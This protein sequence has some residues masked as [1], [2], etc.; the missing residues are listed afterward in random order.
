MNIIIEGLWFSPRERFIEEIASNKPENINNV[1]CCQQILP[2]DNFKEIIR[3]LT[4]SAS[5]WRS[6]ATLTD[7]HTVFEGSPMSLQAY[8]SALLEDKQEHNLFK[9]I[10]DGLEELN[11]PPHLIVIML[12]DPLD[13]PE[14]HHD[15]YVDMTLDEIE[16]TQD[17]LIQ[18]SQDMQQKGCQVINIKPPKSELDWDRWYT[19]VMSIINT[20][21]KG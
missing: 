6:F 19:G 11:N 3:A 9:Q 12:C 7:D 2:G 13:A 8:T 20:Y 10:T 16:R 5:T 18:W 14:R 1:L 15:L 17:A 21:T 4:S